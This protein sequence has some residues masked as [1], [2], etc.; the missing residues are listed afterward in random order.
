MSPLSAFLFLVDA[1]YKDVGT[2][3]E[4]HKDTNRKFDKLFYKLDKLEDKVDT[5][6]DML[7][8]RLDKQ[9]CL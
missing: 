8:D 4:D 5:K 1:T 3:K 6:F 2:L 7:S 9:S